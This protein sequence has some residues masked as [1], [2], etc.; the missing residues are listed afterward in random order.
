MDYILGGQGR[1]PGCIF[2]RQPA[3]S[4]DPQ[5]LTN[6]WHIEQTFSPLLPDFLKLR[7]D[8]HHE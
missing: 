4:Q 3:Q 5:D 1:A 6:P 8:L 7:Q 2:A